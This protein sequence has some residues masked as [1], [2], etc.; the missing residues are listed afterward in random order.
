MTLPRIFIIIA[1]A[2]LLF[3]ALTLAQAVDVYGQ[4]RIYDGTCDTGIGMNGV[5]VYLYDNAGFLDSTITYTD[6]AFM[7]AHNL[8]SP[9]GIYYFDDVPYSVNYW[10][11]VVPPLGV[12][13]TTDPSQGS[14]WNANPRQV[15][16]NFYRC[17]L[18]DLV[19]SNF[20]PRTMGFWKHQA[21][22]ANGGNGN[23]QVPADELQ[24]MLD[25]LFA[26][27]DN[28]TNFPI[29]GVSSVG[30]E[31]LGFQDMLNTFN[32]PNGGSAGMVNKA[33]KQ[34]LALLMN[35]VAEYV[36]VWQEISVDER[37]ISEAISF[38]ADMI[39]NNGSAIGTAK[40]AMDMINNGQTVPSGWIPSGYGLIYYG[41]EGTLFGPVAS[42]PS[43]E[44]LIGN[45]PNPFNPETRIE[46]S[47]PEASQITLSIY[48]MQGQKVAELLNG[49]LEAG[50][51]GM[52]WNAAGYPSG[53]YIYRL[54]SNRGQ[55]AGTMVLM[56]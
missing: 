13:L 22:V 51:Y 54:S 34:L 31:P 53:T 38:G 9:M 1:V 26:L 27:F 3:G 15:G 24:D 32:A 44:I 25:L 6:V 47:L 37:T 8:T 16:T 11:E 30:G 2:L 50:Q 48:N 12:E 18:M 49:R 52:A 40:D 55:I 17:F 39:T 29:E 56:K 5:K 46:F 20:E 36:Y 10:V 4:V 45:Y 28:G 35:V 41:N 43:T 33:K 19:G 21:T 23:A 14:W 42:L 7:Q